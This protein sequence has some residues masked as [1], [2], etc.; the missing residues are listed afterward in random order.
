MRKKLTETLRRKTIVSTPPKYIKE[1]EILE[2]QTHYDKIE[3][4]TLHK[5]FRSETNNQPEIPRD[6]FVKGLISMGVEDPVLHNIVF[7]VF[8]PRNTGT[9]GFK[10]FVS[11]LSVM[12][13][14]T[15]DEKLDFLFN[16]YDI[17]DKGYLDKENTSKIME[18]FCSLVG[19][20]VT[21][22]G[23]RFESH[24]QLVDEFFAQM[25]TTGDGKIT[26]EEYREEA[27]KNPDIIQGLKLGE[28]KN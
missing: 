19:P 23:K 2:K 28:D 18:A 26:L 24:E 21:F 12:T 10:E 3:L 14:G 1:F 7:N 5:L 6:V 16:S 25:D 13:R 17:D 22:S 11:A 9:I 4:E 15:P 20:L 8:D 27:M